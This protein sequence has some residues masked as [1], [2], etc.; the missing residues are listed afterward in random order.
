MRSIFMSDGGPQARNELERF[1]MFHWPM[2][3]RVLLP[4]RRLLFDQKANRRNNRPINIHGAGM[5]INALDTSQSTSHSLGPVPRLYSELGKYSAVKNKSRNSHAPNAKKTLDKKLHITK[6]K[7]LTVL[8]FT[9]IDS[10]LR[11]EHNVLVKRPRKAQPFWARWRC[12]APERTLTPCYA[13][14]CFL[15]D[16]FKPRDPHLAMSLFHQPIFQD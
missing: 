13:L 3:K 16:H 1:V 14:R 15:S 12:V 4:G 10:I 11:G 5:T 2:E 8:I 6:A 9:C 7:R